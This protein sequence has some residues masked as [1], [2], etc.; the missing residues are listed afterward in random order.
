MVALYPTADS[1]RIRGTLSAVLRC[2]LAV[3]LVPGADRGGRV[4]ATELL[5]VDDAAREII[6][7]GALSQIDLLIRLSGARAGHC[8]R[9]D[10]G[11][12]PGRAHLA[13][14]CHR[15]PA[16]QRAHPL[17]AWQQRG[18][19]GPRPRRPGLDRG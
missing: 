19:L 8:R 3:Q 5:V 16:R 10:R 12:S 6:S 18:S 13:Q 2:V 1:V 15:Q 4:L 14:P 11:Q 7:E 17:H 9:S